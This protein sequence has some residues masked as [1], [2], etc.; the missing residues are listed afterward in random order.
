[1]IKSGFRRITALILALS[2]VA[3]FATEGCAV[4]TSETVGGPSSGQ[5]SCP[6]DGG[7]LDSGVVD[8]CSTCTDTLCKLEEAACKAGSDCDD[9]NQCATMCSDE[10][11]MRACGLEHGHGRRDSQALADC[12]K[13]DCTGSCG[14]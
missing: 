1:M 3:P 8:S 9:Y 4:V 13:A 5:G 2:G 12:T 7:S 14:L 6:S 11:C 10:A